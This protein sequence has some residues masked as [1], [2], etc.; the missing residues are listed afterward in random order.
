MSGTEY[1]ESLRRCCPRVFVNGRAAESVADEPLFAPGIAAIGVTYDA[2]LAS[3]S[4]AL[5]TARQHTSGA[6]V[7]RMLHVDTSGDD[8]FAKLEAVRLLCRESGCAQQLSEPRRAE[9]PIPSDL[10]HRRGARHEIPRAAARI[11]ASRAG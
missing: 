11:F 7:N 10:R 2:A 4:A 3:A 1:R 8:L 5:M 9:R 6:V